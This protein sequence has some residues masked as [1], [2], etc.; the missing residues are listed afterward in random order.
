MYL[1]VK[2]QTFAS[3]ATNI[4]IAFVKNDH[5]ALSLIASFVSWCHFDNPPS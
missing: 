4:E 5:T 2:K 3:L 1:D